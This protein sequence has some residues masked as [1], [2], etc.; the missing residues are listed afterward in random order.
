MPSPFSKRWPFWPIQAAR[1][2]SSRDASMLVFM[3]ARFERDGMV[4]DDRP[5]DCC[6]SLVYSFEYP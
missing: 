5:A 4:L 3:S 2:T 6:R 1:Q